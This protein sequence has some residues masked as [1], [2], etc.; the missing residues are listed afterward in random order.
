MTEKSYNPEQNMKSAPVSESKPAA[1]KMEKK[2]T[3]KE[4]VEKDSSEVKERKKDVKIK[5]VKKNEAIVR[6]LSVPI[7][8]KTSIEICRFIKGKSIREVVDYL[9]LTA[10]GKKAIPMRG[11]IPHR[12]GFKDIHQRK[13]LMSGRYP[14]NASEGFIRLLRSV[15]SNAVA[16]GIDEPVIVSAVA[17]FASRPYG[18][19]G[20]NR[21]KRTHI[22]I[23][24]MEKS[25]LL[26]LKAKKL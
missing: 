14:K 9:E 25:K 22:T 11:E 8:T 17:N 16:N 20:R 10:K 15:G 3:S 18:R 2:K 7:S 1:E 12:H 26:E 23:K 5:T 19:F 13:R 4:K 21:K 6:G 24:V